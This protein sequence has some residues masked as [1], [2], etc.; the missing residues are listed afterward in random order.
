[1]LID[2]AHIYDLM[3]N[4]ELSQE[5]DTFSWR[6]SPDQCYSAASAYGAMFLG[7]TPVFGAKQVW[8]TADP[9]RVRFFF[10]LAVHNRCWTGA[11]RFRHGL[12]DSDTIRG[13]K[14]WT[15]SFWA[16]VSAKK[17]GISV[18][19]GCTLTWIPSLGAF[20][21]GMVDQL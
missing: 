12:Q 10:W 16:A 21:A 13:L 20:G 17:F 15:T 5:P 7:S 9:P 1:M 18:W 3:E 11:R 19:G 4:F 6:L 14:R 8:K 2:I